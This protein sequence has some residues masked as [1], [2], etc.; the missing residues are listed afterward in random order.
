MNA[1]MKRTALAIRAASLVRVLAVP[2]SDA[3]PAL[4]VDATPAALRSS[5]IAATVH[6]GIAGRMARSR[7]L[8]GER[9][10]R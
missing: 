4:L 7:C 8:V 10:G 1:G 6:S 9:L 5:L 2:T 3:V